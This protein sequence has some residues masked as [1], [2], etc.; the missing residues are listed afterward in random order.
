M[1]IANDMDTHPEYS[2]WL[3]GVFASPTHRRRGIGRAL[4]EH[5]VHEAAGLGFATLYLYTPN[6]QDFYSRLG[7]ST[8]Q[9]TRYRDTDAT[10][11]SHPRRLT[12]RCSEP[13]TVLMLSFNCYANINSNAR[14]R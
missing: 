14:G 8:L 10:I 7:W 1:L 13:R 4:S 9:R 2:P 12:R 5:V 3:A 11:M 6:A